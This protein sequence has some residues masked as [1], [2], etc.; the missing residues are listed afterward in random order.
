[1]QAVEYSTAA[2]AEQYKEHLKSDERTQGQ[3][4]VSLENLQKGREQ[5]CQDFNLIK[6]NLEDQAKGT[7]KLTQAVA[8]FREEYENDMELAKKKIEVSEAT[9]TRLKDLAGKDLDQLKN[10]MT[11]QEQFMK[12]FW[13]AAGLVLFAFAKFI[14]ELVKR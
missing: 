4:E 3:I 8:E 6:L 5:M 9:A 10:I 2:L 11:L 12:L 1:M 13:A 7:S 14:W